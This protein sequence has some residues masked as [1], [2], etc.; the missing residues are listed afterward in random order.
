MRALADE[1]A[2]VEARRTMFK[3]A[4]EYGR[5]GDRAADRLVQHAKQSTPTSV[6]LARP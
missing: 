1:A 6:G 3:L 2:N 5:L 4:D